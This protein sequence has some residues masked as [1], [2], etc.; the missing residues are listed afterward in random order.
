[1]RFA[2]IHS[3]IAQKAGFGI[4]SMCR[5]LDVTRQGYYAYAKA[6]RRPPSD[7]DGALRKRIV[8]VH[9]SSGRTYGSPRVY[10][11]LR[12][13]GFLAGK[14]RIERVMRAEG[15]VGMPRGHSRLTTRSNPDHAVAPNTLSRQFTASKPNERW[16][17]DITYIWTDEGWCYL[18]AILDLF[19]RRVVGWQLSTSLSTELPLDALNRALLQRRPEGPLL[20]HSDRGCQYTSDQYRSRLAEV[21]IS[22][23]MSRR[24]NC[25]DN[26][27]AESFFATL[28]TELIYSR[29]R[30]RSRIELRSALFEYLETFYNRRRLHSALKYRSPAD[31]EAEYEAAA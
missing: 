5:V 16:V 4:A 31:F 15:I 11:E 7:E 28:K 19:S 21:G 20:H 18:A 26:A 1:M 25:W 24:G 22:V 23:S 17:T 12:R 29:R 30:W 3:M 2:F 8:E 14:H 9:A 13:E 27:V 6:L 10:R